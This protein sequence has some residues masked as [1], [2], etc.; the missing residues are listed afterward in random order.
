MTVSTEIANL[1]LLLL[2]SQRIVDLDN[3]TSARALAI[4]D[5]YAQARRASLAAAP[6]QFALE[7][8]ELQQ[9]TAPSAGFAYRYVVPN[10]VCRLVR[11]SEFSD[12][13]SELEAFKF[14]R[15][16]YLDT[17]AASVFIEYVDYNVTDD[18]LPPWFYDVFAAKLA[19]YTARPIKGESTDFERLEKTFQ[20]RLYAGK[21]MD[22][23]QQAPKRLPM[24]GWVLAKYGGR[25][26]PW[27]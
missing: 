15:N 24:G 3:D 4:R 8:A 1:T 6:W 21:T 16:R 25:R 14:R 12:L 23:A 13:S 27:R 22:G 9:T 17:D 19:Y 11:I 18:E 26:R 7:V 20:Q 5:A 10:N 2:G